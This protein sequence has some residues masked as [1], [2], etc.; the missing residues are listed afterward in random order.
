MKKIAN[1]CLLAALLMFTMTVS[2][3]AAPINGAISFSGTSVANNEDLSQA[4]AFTSFSDVVVSSTGGAEDYLGVM[5][6]QN[7]P[8]EVRMPGSF[9]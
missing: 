2:A 5:S 1:I 7:D 3:M 4:T 6:G 8:S 9:E